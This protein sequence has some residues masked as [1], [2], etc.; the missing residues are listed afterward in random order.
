MPQT[1]PTG[2]VA[3][4]EVH[5]ERFVT[6]LSIAELAQVA[7]DGGQEVRRQLHEAGLPLVGIEDGWVVKVW[8]D[9][10]RERVEPATAD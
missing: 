5:D 2:R 9:G 10:R 1:H 6:D 4:E 8:P 7:W 3:V